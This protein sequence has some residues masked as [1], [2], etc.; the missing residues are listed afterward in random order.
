MVKNLPAMQETW[1]PG[2]GRSPGEENG[3][4]LQYFCLRK[5]HGQRSL[6][7]YSPWGP[8]E[9]DMTSAFICLM[10]DSVYMLMLLSPFVPL[11]PSLTVTTS[12][13]SVSSSPLLPCK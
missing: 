13:F 10:R 1:I 11:S 2:S 5:S 8:K 9:S 6:V 3:Y 4:P 12:L 7:D